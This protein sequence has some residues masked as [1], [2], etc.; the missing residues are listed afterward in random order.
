MLRAGGA[1]VVA[2]WKLTSTP[3]PP[4]ARARPGVPGLITRGGVVVEHVEGVG[5]VAHPEGDAKGDVRLDLG[6]HRSRGSLGREDEVH[7]ERPAQGGEPHQARHEVGE[8]LDQGPQLVDHDDQARA[9]ASLSGRRAALVGLEVAGADLG[10][11]ALAPSQL[12]PQR[13][14]GPRDEVV[15]EVGDQADDVGERGAGPKAAPPLKSTSTKASSSGGD[16][17]ASEVTSV[18]R[19]SDLPEPV[20]PPTRTWGPSRTRSMTNGPSAVPPT[21]ARGVGGRP[22]PTPERAPARAPPLGHPGV[23]DLHPAE[24]VGEGE[25]RRHP[26]AGDL[27]GAAQRGQG[28]G[29]PVAPPRARPGRARTA[30]VAVGPSST[31]APS[32][33][34]TTASHSDGRPRAAATPPSGRVPRPARARRTSVAVSGPGSGMTTTLQDRAA[35]TPSTPRAAPDRRVA[36]A[37]CGSRRAQA[38]PGVRRDHRHRRARAAGWPCTAARRGSRARRRWWRAGPRTPRHGIARR[39]TT[40]G[41]VR[42]GRAGPGAA[43]DPDDPGGHVTQTQPDH[44]RPT[45]APQPGTMLLGGREDR[46]RVGMRPVEPL[47]LA[48]QRLARAG[49]VHVP[50]PRR[51]GRGRAVAHDPT[52]SGRRRRRRA[53]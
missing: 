6:A 49:S 14:Q 29:E 12:G 53:G 31:C 16:D 45:T 51:A 50:P 46:G 11:Q 43:V 9:P 30:W 13:G 19:N 36:R 25:A 52:P 26:G 20:V 21:T 40:N 5:A 17:R 18:R 47:P 41:G 7:A 4:R 23:G 3:S 37:A 2:A 32:S 24:R 39:S 33:S 48:G 8:L 28:T 42:R 15:V 10:E 35:A 34:T 22:A 1:D 27:L 44:G 38:H